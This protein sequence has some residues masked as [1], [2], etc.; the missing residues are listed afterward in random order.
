MERIGIYYRV[1]TEKQD[2]ESQKIAVEQWLR[3]LPPA[4]RP[5]IEPLVF[6]DEGISGKTLNRPGFQALLETAY[7]RKIDTIVVYKLDRFSRDATTAINLLLNLDQAGV[8]FISVTQPVLNLGHENPF[9]RTM[10]AAFAEIAEIERETIVAR[11]RAGLDAARKRGVKLGAPA[12][13]SD[14]KQQRAVALK[15]QGQS[16]KAIANTLNLSVGTVHKMIKLAEGEG[17][18]DAVESEKNLEL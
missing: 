10:L 17:I 12:K 11:V 18:A 4:K 7:A 1:S 15:A 6:T 5:A 9:R 13:I 8:A 16:Y 14:E 3:D 2:L